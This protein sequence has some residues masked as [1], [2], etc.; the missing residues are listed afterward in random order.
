MRTEDKIANFLEKMDFRVRCTILVELI[1]HALKTIYDARTYEWRR[2]RMRIG[3]VALKVIVRCPNNEKSSEFAYFTIYDGH[4]WRCE[5]DTGVLDTAR[6]PHPLLVRLCLVGI[7]VK[8]SRK[9][10]LCIYSDIA[11][12][13]RAT[14]GGRGHVSFVH[15]FLLCILAISR[16]RMSFLAQCVFTQMKWS[17]K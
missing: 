16:W 15:T 12:F 9:A 17:N 13:V 11:N 6:L 7:R 8:D 3:F 4:R 1:L 5:Y 2:K 14:I 10:T